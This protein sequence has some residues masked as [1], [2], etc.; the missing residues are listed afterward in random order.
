MG[1]CLTLLV[2]APV[3]LSTE[4]SGQPQV[5]DPDGPEAGIAPGPE[6]HTSLGPGRWLAAAE[7]AALA[8]AVGGCFA[9]RRSGGLRL[10]SPAGCPRSGT[11]QVRRR[12]RARSNQSVSGRA[13]S[14]SMI[15][16]PSRI[17]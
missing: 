16:M 15:G 2:L 10:G 8:V 11:S 1:Y 6:P 7:V 4:T 14:G 12:L 9:V 3:D 17:G 5:R 13:S